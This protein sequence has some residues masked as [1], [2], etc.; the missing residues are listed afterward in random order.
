VLD[1]DPRH[2]GDRA[3]QELTANHE[4]SGDAAL[5]VAMTIAL[6]AGAEIPVDADGIFIY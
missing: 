4:P 2:G 5:V 1:V 3:L 6:A